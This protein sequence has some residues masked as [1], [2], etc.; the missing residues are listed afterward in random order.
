MFYFWY[1]IFKNYISKEKDK[2]EKSKLTCKKKSP[3]IY[4]RVGKDLVQ[5]PLFFFYNDIYSIVE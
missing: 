3:K 2:E 5:A 1:V 4:S